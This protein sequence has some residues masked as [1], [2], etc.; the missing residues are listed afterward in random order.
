MI[1]LKRIE[2]K[3]MVPMP[4]RINADTPPMDRRTSTA[5]CDGIG[6][7]LRDVLKPSENELPPRLQE[8]MDRLQQLDAAEAPSIAPTLD[9]PFH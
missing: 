5:V 9:R 3:R 6:E 1:D 7:R 2:L 8:L 4:N